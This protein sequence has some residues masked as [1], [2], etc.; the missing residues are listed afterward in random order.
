MEARTRNF[1]LEKLNFRSFIFNTYKITQK[2][3]VH[4]LHS[5]HALTDLRVA[6][7]TFAGRCSPDDSL[8]VLSFGRLPC[9]TAL[10]GLLVN[11]SA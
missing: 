10:T 6:A 7:R 1:Q 2:M 9:A 4:A 5:V 3:S 8:P 11:F